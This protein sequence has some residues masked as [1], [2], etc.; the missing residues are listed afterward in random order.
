MHEYLRVGIVQSTLDYRSAW[1][2]SPK[3]DSLEEKKAENEIDR[4]MNSF[5]AETNRPQIIV[6]P[7]LAAPHFM[8][9]KLQRHADRLE[10]IVVAGMDYRLSDLGGRLTAS[11][12][13][14]LFVPKRWL[15]SRTRSPRTRR[16]IG[17]TYPSDAEKRALSGFSR[18]FSGDPFVW[19]FDG[20]D[21][22]RF[23]IAICYDFLDLERLAMYRGRIHHFFVLAYNRDVNSFYYVAEA[24]ARMACCN[25]VVCNTGYFGGS[26]AVSPYREPFRRTIYRSEGAKLF[27][28]QI[29]ELPVESLDKHQKAPTADKNAE[30]KGLPP[31][32]TEHQVLLKKETPLF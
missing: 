5:A 22:G 3:M 1:R 16:V 23:A 31:G 29:V 2:S 13:A 12:E 10:A 24:F 18:E 19:L 28:S 26:L 15:G 30:F 11:N 14:I 32:Y 9:A 8:I 21:I 17:K 20:G 7:E 27:T 6:A 25:V 4:S